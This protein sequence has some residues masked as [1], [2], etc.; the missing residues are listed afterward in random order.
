MRTDAG[1]STSGG[2]MSPLTIYGYYRVLLAAAIAGLFFANFD[3]S[4]RLGSYSPQL[5]LVTSVGY[6]LGALL[7]TFTVRLFASRA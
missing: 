2:R 4:V 5:F 7:S 1:L 6:F 3:S